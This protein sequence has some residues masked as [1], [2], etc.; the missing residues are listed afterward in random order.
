MHE[1]ATLDRM[2]A[3]ALA[4]DPA[5][6][7]VE[8]AGD[9]VCWGQLRG[10]AERVGA[11]L[12]QS[13]C[14][15]QTEVAFVAHNRPSAA[16]ALLG[17][18]AQARTVR[19]VYGFQSAAGIA[20]DLER[21]EP[22][23]VVAAGEVF[24][25]EVLEVLRARGAAA[26]ALSELHAAAVPGFE[27]SRS[28]TSL[29]PMPAE[30]QILTSGTTGSP[31]RFGMTHDMV[32]RHIV[33]ANKNYRASDI[34]LSSEP[35]LFSY[36]PLGNI[37]GLYGVLPP[38]LRGHRVVLVER[39]SVQEWL[40]YLRR[41][42]PE[43][44]SLPPAGFQMVLEA[45]VPREE[46]AG[47]RSIAS[48]A[49]PLD[50]NVHRAF[51]ARYEIPILLSYGATEFAGPV[52][53]MTPE[54]HARWG[55]TK[56]GS[57]GRPIAGARLRVVD[58]ETGE[59]LAPGQEGIL[60]V[61]A[62]RIGPDWIRTTDLAVVDA[63][64]FLFHRGRADGAILRGGFKVLPEP[65]ERALLLHPAVAEVMVV[66]LAD[67]RL[68]Q[69]PAAVVQLKRDALEPGIDELERHLRGHVYATH[70]PVAWR[71]V[72]EL[73]RTA[74]FKVDRRAA[75]DLFEPELRQST[76]EAR[77]TRASSEVRP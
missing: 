63:D 49:A 69:V 18:L 22:A 1:E 41:Y 20:R 34:D 32:L 48:G 46:L 60:E 77:K 44:A 64:E 67:T 75:R 17:M 45:A 53:S 2:C 13:G 26:I 59:V 8:F 28:D 31:K 72:E 25:P 19:M 15:A 51:E 76:T 29:G 71:V 39:F 57:A 11:L 10:L 43:R 14:H 52:T 73:P 7:A 65:I 74:S 33:S 56:L 70:I 35:P 4:R 58:P 66:G 55:K 36:Y 61:I 3:K 9:W 24:S 62:P 5:R 6:E 23:V 38:L 37:S 54:L 68:G 50:P 21:L 30:I 12:E 47:L 27:L 16:G 42:R 40:R